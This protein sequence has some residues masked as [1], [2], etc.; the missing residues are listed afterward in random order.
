M[1]WQVGEDL[2]PFDSDRLETLRIEAER[3]EQ[4][5]RNLR[6]LH[7]Y[8]EG[9]RRERWFRQYRIAAPNPALGAATIRERPVD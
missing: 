2:R 3:L 6:G 9:L 1:L 7:R 4:R 5:R 8:R